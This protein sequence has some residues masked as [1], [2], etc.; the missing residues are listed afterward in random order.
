MWC[1]ILIKPINKSRWYFN[2][3]L[4]LSLFLVGYYKRSYLSVVRCSRCRHITF[5]TIIHLGFVL[6]LFLFIT[7]IFKQSLWTCHFL[8][9]Q[10]L[11]TFFTIIHILWLFSSIDMLRFVKHPTVQHRTFAENFRLISVHCIFFNILISATISDTLC[12]IL[13]LMILFEYFL[14]SRSFIWFF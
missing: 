12:I 6:L 2:G 3:S 4:F 10:Y 9:I 1:L 5:F 11:L 8:M 7:H 14:I 13:L